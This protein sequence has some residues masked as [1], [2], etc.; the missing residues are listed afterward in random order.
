MTKS[1]KQMLN[2]TALIVEFLV[3]AAF[4]FSSWLLY[5]A[6]AHRELTELDKQL[7]NDFVPYVLLFALVGGTCVFGLG[8]VIHFACWRILKAKEK[9]R[10]ADRP[11]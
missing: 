10:A 4:A 1:V 7:D 6:L 5:N 2:A 11:A 8:F 3:F 9:R